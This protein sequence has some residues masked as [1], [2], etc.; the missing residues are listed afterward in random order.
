MFSRTH[1]LR[2]VRQTA[3]VLHLAVL[4]LLWLIGTPASAVVVIGLGSLGGGFS[5][6]KGIN[7][8]GQIVGESSTGN[9]TYR[10]FIWQNGSMSDLGTLP[11]LH[12]SYANG[13]NNLGQIVGAANTNP[14]STGTD[15]AFLWQNNTMVGLGTFGQ[16]TSVGLS[17]NQ[18]GQIAGRANSTAFQ[19][20]NGTGTTNLGGTASAASINDSGQIVG[21]AR[22]ANYPHAVLWQNGVLSDLGT[23]GGPLSRALDINNAGVIVGTAQTA[24]SNGKAFRWENGLMT[25]LGTLGGSSSGAFGI[26]S[27]GQIV[28]EA[29]DASQTNHAF[30]W[31]DGVMIDLNSLVTGTGWTLMNATAINDNGW[32]IGWG[33]GPNGQRGYLLTGVPEPSS[34]ILAGLSVAGVAARRWRRRKAR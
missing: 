14:A 19:W 15:Q 17:I 4:A 1:R 34:M 9:G 10:G 27:S 8:A 11:G 16:P 6:P 31:Q 25:N 12:N 13:I 33:F 2:L 32:I 21:E 30:L 20:Q 23:F 24:D 3:T 29:R 26:N 22:V 5:V 7:N 28:G 18:V